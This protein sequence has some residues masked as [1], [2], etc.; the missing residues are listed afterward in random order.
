MDDPCKTCNLEFAFPNTDLCENC[1]KRM[2]Y[3]YKT[4][5]AKEK[6]ANCTEC[7]FRKVFEPWEGNDAVAHCGL[8]MRIDRNAL[9]VDENTSCSWGDKK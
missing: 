2:V 5:Q 9:I 1:H 4:A 6:V 7:K 8:L 3:L